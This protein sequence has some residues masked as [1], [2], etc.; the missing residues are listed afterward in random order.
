MS[1][2]LEDISSKELLEIYQKNNQ[3]INFI[4]KEYEDIEKM[5]EDKW[6]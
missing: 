3:F 2:E 1:K 6:K 4:K 5:R